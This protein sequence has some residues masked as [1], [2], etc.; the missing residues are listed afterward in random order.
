LL[1]VKDAAIELCGTADPQ[2][3]ELEMIMLEPLTE[4]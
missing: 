4:D 3:H 1:S 2:W